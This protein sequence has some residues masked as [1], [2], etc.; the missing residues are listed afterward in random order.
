MADD[1]TFWRSQRARE[2]PTCGN[3]TLPEETE[4]SL[5]GTTLQND[6]PASSPPDVSAPTF[7]VPPQLEALAPPVNYSPLPPS[8]SLPPQGDSAKANSASPASVRPP[9]P[10][11]PHVQVDSPLRARPIVQPDS[12]RPSLLQAYATF[13][14]I[15]L[16][17]AA[18][19]LLIL[20]LL[21]GFFLSANPQSREASN[22]PEPPP[23][24]PPQVIG[25]VTTADQLMPVCIFGADANDELRGVAALRAHV[26][27]G[28]ESVRDSYTVQLLTSPA[29]FGTMILEF[30]V[31]SEG[32]VSRAAVH[33]TGMLSP[34]LQQRVLDI[35]K[36]WRFPSAQ[37]GEVKV[38]YPLL[39][40]P[41]KVDSATLTTRFTEVW[42]GWYK[43]LSATPVSVHVEAS[44]HAQQVGEIG[45]GLRVYI[46]SSRE[47]WLEVLSPSGEVGYVP[48]EAIS[49]RV[50]NAI[51]G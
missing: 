41:E 12:P 38:F 26:E 40:S 47:G 33:A 46:I 24:P 23:P 44:A 18:F 6:A 49:P 4:C 13:K 22:E 42:P 2:C 43:V 39:L 36:G 25:Q 45:P 34:E 5:C 28:L 16:A 48:R 51:P 1:P 35:M 10:S 17:G 29:A 20:G 15:H 3:N 7:V 8:L 27:A 14:W 30:S 31:T 9:Q 37:G 32:T 50:E 19:A 11:P 21:T